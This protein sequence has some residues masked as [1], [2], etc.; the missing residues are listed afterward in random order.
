MS[1]ARFEVLLPVRY[2]N[3]SEVEPEKLDRVRR[4]LLARFGGVTVEPRDIEGI[5]VQD[6]EAY[7]DALMRFVVDA[8]DCI[9]NEHFFRELKERLKVEFRQLDV[10]VTVHSLRVL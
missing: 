3:G 2:N 5:W 9:E 8:D 6:G 4:E 7:H 1:T 10:W